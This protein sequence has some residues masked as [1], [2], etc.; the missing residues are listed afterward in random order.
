MK[1]SVLIGFVL[2]AILF[3]W[4]APRVF[5]P[6]FGQAALT[7]ALISEKADCRNSRGIPLGRRSQE[8][9]K[10]D[11]GPPSQSMRTITC[12]F[13]AAHTHSHRLRRPWP[14]RP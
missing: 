8:S 10:W 11:L 13:L 12:G 9:G 6:A 14:R 1:R 3:V 4:M 7:R 5:S 2:T